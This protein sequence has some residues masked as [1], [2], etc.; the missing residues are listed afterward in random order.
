MVKLKELK[1]LKT[2]KLE[3][4]L[5]ELRLEMQKMRA[6]HALGTLEKPG[7]L[8]ATRR[9]IAKILTLLQERRSAKSG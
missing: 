2:E 9:E 6:K 5:K 4:R 7:L 8:R 3:S 1:G